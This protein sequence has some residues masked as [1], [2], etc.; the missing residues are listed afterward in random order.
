MLGNPR[1]VPAQPA[2]DAADPPAG[3]VRSLGRE[4]F[5]RKWLPNDPRCHGGDGLGPVYNTDSC[6]DCHNLG[7]PGGA[8]P[9]GQNVEVAT[10]IG[11]NISPDSPVVIM[12][13]LISGNVGLD[14]V[15]TDPEPA[16]LLRIHPGFRDARSTVLHRFGVDPDYSRWRA[17]FRSQTRPAVPVPRS[18][19]SRQR[20]TVRS[21]SRDQFACYPMVIEGVDGRRATFLSR[22]VPPAPRFSS[23]RSSRRRATVRSQSRDE[24][25]VIPSA[26]LYLSD[27]QCR[28]LKSDSAECRE[29][30]RM[31]LD[32]LG[33]NGVAI[34]ITARNPPP[35]FGTGLIDEVTLEELQRVARQQPPKTRGGFIA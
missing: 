27:R 23:S 15:A 33:A 34:A 32:Q 6:L 16:D 19:S 21:Q 29:A 14:M 20:A 10:G 12:G 1:P 35:L 5:A 3:D 4:L 7:G 24:D 31:C 28:P 18:L 26:N 30:V 8:G 13:N 11:Y 25:P 17:A 2:A 9:A 22:S